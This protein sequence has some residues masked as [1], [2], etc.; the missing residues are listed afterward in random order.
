[1]LTSVTVARSPEKLRGLL[2]TKHGVASTSIDRYLT[3]HHGDATDPTT[4][5]TVL[6]NPHD[7]NLL[8]DIILSGLG[9]YPTFQWSV[10]QPL[11]LSDPTICE[12]AIATIFTAISK[13]THS[14]PA[15]NVSSGS[16]KLPLLV[17]I[18]TAGAG[19]R[20]GLP[21]SILLPYHY[22]LSSPLADKVNMEKLIFEDEGRHVRDFVVIRPPFLS[23]GQAKGIDSL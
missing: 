23:D 4:V 13:F 12:R 8:V 3:I 2:T 7:N 11:I 22:L 20:R 1:M 21:L 17:V 6:T 5:A 9:A 10:V 16:Q 15:Y 14:A 19:R 18:S